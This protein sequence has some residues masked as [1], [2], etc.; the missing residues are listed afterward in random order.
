VALAAEPPEDIPDG[1][2]WD[3]VQERLISADEL[4]EQDAAALA[5]AEGWSLD[6][7]LARL[8]TSLDTDAA[9]AEVARLPGFAGSYWGDGEGAGLTVL[10]S[11]EI[12]EAAVDEVRALAQVPVETKLVPDRDLDGAQTAVGQVLEGIKGVRDWTTAVDPRAQVVQVTVLVPDAATQARVEAALA[13]AVPEHV[14]QLELVVAAAASSRPLHDV[15]L[16]VT[17][18]KPAP[19]AAIAKRIRSSKTSVTGPGVGCGT[20][21]VALAPR[22]GVCLRVAGSQQRTSRAI[23]RD[24][25]RGNARVSGPGEAC[26]ADP[27]PL[28]ATPTDGLR[29]VLEVPWEWLE[30]DPDGMTLRVVYQDGPFA[31]RGLD[32]VEAA[33]SDAGLRVRVFAGY[34]PDV[35]S[36]SGSGMRWMATVPLDEPIIDERPS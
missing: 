11:G 17:E 25:V 8:R 13:E 1:M 35:I 33:V 3:P 31:C 2:A 21:Q 16:R 29:N 12:P 23:A 36:C 32:H 22:D 15:C 26:G 27:V 7:A 18:T 28:V 24:V 6:Y 5:E 14:V 10:F 34:R 30:I 4:L 9:M 19:V 20:G